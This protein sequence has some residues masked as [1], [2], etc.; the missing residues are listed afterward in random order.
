V[1]P[2]QDN[3]EDMVKKLEKRSTV[4][5]STPTTYNDPQEKNSRKEQGW[6]SQVPISLNQAQGTR[7]TLQEA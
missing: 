4:I 7:I 2:S 1:Q 5:S 6:A 3:R